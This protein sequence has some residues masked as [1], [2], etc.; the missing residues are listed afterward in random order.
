MPTD[1]ARA[2]AEQLADYS[3][4]ISATRDGLFE[5]AY[6]ALSAAEARG[7]AQALEQADAWVTEARDGE[8][9]MLAKLEDCQRGRAQ[10]E[11]E[12]EHKYAFVKDPTRWMKWC[13]IRVLERAEYAEAIAADAKAQNERL[14]E[15]VQQAEQATYDA[16][17]KEGERIMREIADRCAA[18]DWNPS[19]GND[20]ADPADHLVANINALLERLDCAEQAGRQA[21]LEEA[22]EYVA[23]IAEKYPVDVFPVDGVSVDCHSARVMRHASKFISEDLRARAAEGGTT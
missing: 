4:N 13:D 8:K 15:R 18:F 23:S 6:A 22:A 7:R 1:P 10:A 2:I 14:V 12:V 11:Q 9:R 16:V 21:G 20:S 3:C 5:R 17:T 19:D